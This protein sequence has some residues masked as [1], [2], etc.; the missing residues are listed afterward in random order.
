MKIILQRDK[1]LQLAGWDSPKVIFGK[2]TLTWLTSQPDIYTIVPYPAIPAGNY[3]LIG[4]N[5]DL[6]PNVWEIANVPNHTGILIHNG[7]FA[8]DVTMGDGVL[9]KSDSQNCVL[10]GF[11]MNDTIP[12]I[13]KS[14]L[15]LQYLRTVLGTYPN[16]KVTNLEIDIL[17]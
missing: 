16:G 11:G 1:P 7:N 5:T 17:D 13:T 6:H 3:N 12:M 14:N 4:H 2:L 10:V 15:C 9:H 8:C